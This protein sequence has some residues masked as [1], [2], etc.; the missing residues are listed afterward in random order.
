[1]TDAPP[2]SSSATMPVPTNVPQLLSEEQVISGFHLFLQTALAQ[3]KAERLLDV[4]TLSSAEADLMISGAPRSRVALWKSLNTVHVTGPALC[5]FFG[6]LRSTTDPP[7]VPLPRSR[8]D[9]SAP[10][11]RLSQATCPPVFTPLVKVW[12]STVPTIQA[13]RSEHQHDL[14]RIICDLEP[15]SKP[16]HSGLNRIAADIRAVAIEISQR[17]TFQER[18]QADLQAALDAGRIGGGTRRGNKATATFIPP[19]MYDEKGWGSSTGSRTPEPEPERESEPEPGPARM[20]AREPP[21]AGSS[22]APARPPPSPTTP[23]L[24]PA[25]LHIRETLFASLAD[26]IATTPSLRN[27]LDADPPRAYFSSVALA[28]LNVS[29]TALTPGGGVRGVLGCELTV[30]GCPPPLRPLMLEV[31]AI[32]KDAR[33]YADEDDE[34]AI[35]LAARGRH[36]PEPL[37]DRVRRILESG[38]GYDERER[39]PS[40]DENGRRSAEG[41]AVQFANKVNRLALTVTGMPAFQAYAKDVFQVLR[42]LA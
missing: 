23:P 18:Y 13:L 5:L 34:D 35:R 42:A 28:I 36:I 39:S 11:L 41:R 6:A 9:K 14:A 38:V 19:P 24:D 3:A 17:R 40:A 37:M 21:R 8:P 1:M 10:P 29:L 27:A 20:P 22:T 15:L 12:A 2:S 32:G 25:M 31:G 30:D 16:V 26:V 7:S 4:D 33:H